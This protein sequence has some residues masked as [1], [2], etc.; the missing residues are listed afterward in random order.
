LFTLFVGSLLA[1]SADRSPYG[2]SYHRRAE[3]NAVRDR[4]DTL[5]LHNQRLELD[6]LRR[7]IA[8]EKAILR[9]KA[10]LRDMTRQNLHAQQQQQQQQQ[11]QPPPP[12]QQKPPH[13]QQQQPAPADA[14]KQQGSSYCLCSL[15]SFL[16]PVLLGVMLVKTC[17]SSPCFLF[18]TLG[19]LLPFL[20]FSLLVAN[21]FLP[22]LSFVGFVLWAVP[23]PVVLCL[24][25]FLPAIKCGIRSF[26][27]AAPGRWFRCKPRWFS[28]GPRWRGC[29]SS[30]PAAPLSPGARG[31]AVAQLQD[32]LIQLGHLHP[33]TVRCAKGNYGPFTTKAITTLQQALGQTLT[34]I[35]DTSVQA[36]LQEALHQAPSQ[37]AASTEAS[38]PNAPLQPGAHG[39]D[40]AKLQDILIQLGHLHPSSVRYA[41]G[42]Y[43]P[44][45]TRAI[46]TLQE[47]N[48]AHPTGVFDSSVRQTLLNEINAKSKP[49]TTP[50]S[51]TVQGEPERHWGVTCDKTNQPIVGLRYHKR[52]ADYDLCEAEFKKLSLLEQAGFERIEK[53]QRQAP[54]GFQVCPLPFF[55]FFRGAAPSAAPEPG[56]EKASQLEQDSCN[57]K[58]GASTGAASAG[59]HDERVA[60]LVSMGFSPGEVA[61][62]MEATNGS[63]EHAADLL[64]AHRQE[65][66]P[67]PEPEPEFLPEWES[68]LCDLVEMG[69]EKEAARQQVVMSAG[70][71]KQAVKALV[72]GERTSR[73]RGG[74]Q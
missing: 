14:S 58:L 67:E 9:E 57:A 48:L 71:M 49:T 29:G 42:L 20:F 18:G 7:E 46:A 43:G 5:E 15:F 59:E 23:L 35:Y 24:F 38:L 22:L 41:R 64:F 32:I 60:L 6:N 66:H 34:G 4:Y 8:Y 50:P 21:V 54:R 1:I 47:R 73:P 45:T 36:H 56:Q 72:E 39:P 3:Y 25:F 27:C 37:P 65:P 51:S 63:L 31:P 11:Q 16:F 70:E 55:Q 33:S 12:V 30:V 13:L 26:G 62:A 2:A 69:F 10:V 61:L 44:F 68:V 28:C 19:G 53:S 17:F 52:G 40:V 74:T